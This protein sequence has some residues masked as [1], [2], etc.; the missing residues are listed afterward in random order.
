MKI[1]NK[2]I[3]KKVITRIIGIISGILIL[4]SALFYIAV[5]VLTPTQIRNPEAEHLH[6]RMQLIVEGNQ[7]DFSQDKFQEAYTP[8]AC[9]FSLTETPIHFHD[10]KDQIVHIHWKDITGGQVLKYYGI[11]LVEN[12]IMTST[13]GFSYEDK[14]QIIPKN[15]KIWG[16]LFGTTEDKIKSNEL[17][18][19][20]YSGEQDNF[21]KKDNN[22]FLN[23]KLEDFFETKSLVS[24][25]SKFEWQNLFS[26]KTQAHGD[27][28]IPISKELSS[29]IADQNSSANNNPNSILN[30]DKSKEF[31][32]EELKEINNLLG[33]VVIFIQKDEPTNDQVK[34]KFDNL[35][36][37]E[38]S[39]CGG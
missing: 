32:E 12:P 1:E 25:E 21:S 6:F 28:K 17:K 38:P 36:K 3:T 27:L 18:L 4:A 13:L 9:S 39:V 19:F 16:R 37:L 20:I 11:N 2:F 29:K 31:S 24:Y 23:N 15:N 22:A 35:I 33:N 8:G 7:A 14:G 10:G 5:F 30:P 34:A 26:L